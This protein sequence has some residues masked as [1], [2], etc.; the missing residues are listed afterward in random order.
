ML[1]F[2]HTFRWLEGVAIL[3]TPSYRVEFF[4]LEVAP[5]VIAAVL[6]KAVITYTHPLSNLLYHRGNTERWRIVPV[7]SFK[8]HPWF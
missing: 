5:A 6:T 8:F 1:A 3:R 4:C 7:D 2:P